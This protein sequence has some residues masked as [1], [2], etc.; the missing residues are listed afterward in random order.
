MSPQ[1]FR[2]RLDEEQWSAFVGSGMAT[3]VHGSWREIITELLKR[4]GCDDTFIQDDC[5]PPK[6][7][8][9][10]DEAMAADPKA[11]RSYLFEKFNPSCE[12][13]LPLVY[14]TMFHLPFVSILTTNFDNGFSGL[15]T[16][17]NRRVFLYPELRSVD[18]GAGGI[19]YLHGRPHEPN[20]DLKH[21]I[22]GTQAFDH[23]YAEGA[24]LTAFLREVVSNVNLMV[25]GA[26]LEEP[27]LRNLL[28]ETQALVLKR[29]EGYQIPL[30]KKII[31][32]P[33]EE[34]DPAWARASDEARGYEQKLRSRVVEL[35]GLGFD[36]FTY[37]CL[38]SSSNSDH[39]QLFD[40][41]EQV[42]QYRAPRSAIEPMGVSNEVF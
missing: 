42:A 5:S 35:T 13:P 12:G 25:F 10:A 39:R 4:C 1:E 22:L 26:A 15:A 32:L 19:F 20:F 28:E 21:V 14:V 6:L 24:P 31:V 9:A 30:K 36:V 29:A 3:G 41:I 7:I 8:E 2:R 16:L 40:F 33:R 27:P 38:V 17:A 23:A 18:V 11:Y 37:P 34:P